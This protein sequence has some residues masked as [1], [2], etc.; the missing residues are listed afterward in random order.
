MEFPTSL[1][2]SW[3][4]CLELILGLHTLRALLKFLRTLLSSLRSISEILRNS[5]ASAETKSFTSVDFC[6]GNPVDF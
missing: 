1:F 3:G 5:K 2:Q 4:S 6:A